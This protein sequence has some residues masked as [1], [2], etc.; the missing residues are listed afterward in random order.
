MRWIH[1]HRQSAPMVTDAGRRRGLRPCPMGA[2]GRD[3]CMQDPAH[4]AHWPDICRTCNEKARSR[5]GCGA[6]SAIRE[7]QPAT[8]TRVIAQ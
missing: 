1:G 4:L 8:M 6:S 7:C 2:A 3:V 5:A